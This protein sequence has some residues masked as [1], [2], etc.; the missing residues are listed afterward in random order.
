MMMSIGLIKIN[1]SDRIVS[2]DSFN[3][4]V[5]LLV[6]ASV[7]GEYCQVL[8]LP[9]MPTHF[10]HHVAHSSSYLRNYIINVTIR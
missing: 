10:L 1:L 8:A 3:C 5:D 6:F 9:K 2:T 7:V 4:S